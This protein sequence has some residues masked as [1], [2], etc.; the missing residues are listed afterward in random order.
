MLFAADGLYPARLAAS[1]RD[2]PATTYCANDSC[3]VLES[4]IGEQFLATKLANG[5]FYKFIAFIRVA[6]DQREVTHD[7]TLAAVFPID[8]AVEDE[9]AGLAG[10]Y[11]R[12]RIN[13]EQCISLTCQARAEGVAFVR[14]P[15]YE[16]SVQTE[17][18]AELRNTTKGDV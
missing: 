14:V 9:S 5:F 18:L 2:I 8:V 17:T 7:L 4:S 13:R 15:A 16:A 6:A 11:R 1:V 10:I 12:G 3:W